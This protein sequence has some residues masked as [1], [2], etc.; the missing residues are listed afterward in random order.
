[1]QRTIDDDVLSSVAD[2]SI[3]RACGFALLGIG[4]V[5]FSLS[6]DLALSLHMGA[7]LLALLTLG[8]VFA[9]W[10]A[11]RRDLRDTEAW[12]ELVASGRAHGVSRKEVSPRLGAKLRER[13]FWHAERVGAATMMVGALWLLVSLA[14]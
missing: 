1:M 11:P 9:G 3:R 10:K 12:I 7:E 6:Y 8:L 4:M 2:L 5:M 13:L 14:R